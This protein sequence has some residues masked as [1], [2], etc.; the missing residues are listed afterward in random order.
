[1]LRANSS[2]RCSKFRKSCLNGELSGR[3]AALRAQFSAASKHSRICSLTL[4]STIRSSL[5]RGST[6]QPQSWVERFRKRSQSSCGA[7]NSSVIKENKKA[8]RASTR[9]LNGDSKRDPRRPT[10]RTRRCQFC[11]LK[12]F[13]LL[14]VAHNVVVRL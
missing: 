14:T 6:D 10:A 1:M 12:A 11:S 8:P 3:V 4:S 13:G 2:Q 7:A 5:A 9:S